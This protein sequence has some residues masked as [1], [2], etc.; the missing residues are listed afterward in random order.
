MS[1]VQVYRKSLYEYAMH[2]KPITRVF[3]GE[4]VVSAATDVKAGD[5]GADQQNS[6]DCLQK[7]QQ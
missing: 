6:A 3:F 1:Q 5:G 2:M 7:V 4:T